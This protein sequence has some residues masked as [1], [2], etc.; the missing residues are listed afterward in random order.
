[1]DSRPPSSPYF[2]LRCFLRSCQLPTSSSHFAT[3]GFESKPDAIMGQAPSALETCISGVANG[4]SGFAGYP[5]NPLYQIQW[6]KPYNLDVHVTPAAVVRPQTAKDVS[7][8]IQ[9]AT[10]NGKKVQ[11]KSGGHSYANYG[12][13]ILLFT[14]FFWRTF[15]LI[16]SQVLVARMELLPSTWSISSI[17]RWT[18]PHGRPRWALEHAW[19]R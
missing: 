16:F 15:V 4:R 5:S 6:V 11:A 19:A 17:S 12:E 18:P 9:C 3:S 10:A 7:L 1:V 13:L 2:S 14:L 8:V